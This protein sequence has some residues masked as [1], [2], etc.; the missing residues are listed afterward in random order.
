[1][2]WEQAETLFS[3]AER[4]KGN[5]RWCQEILGLSTRV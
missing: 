5:E 3:G 4:E 1:M 2:A